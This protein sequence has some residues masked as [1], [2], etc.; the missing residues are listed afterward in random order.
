VFIVIASDKNVGVFVPFSCAASLYEKA[1][2]DCH[3]TVIRYYA[4]DMKSGYF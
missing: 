1:F 3:V 2:G 4:F